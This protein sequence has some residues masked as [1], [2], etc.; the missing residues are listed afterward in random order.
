ML[1]IEDLVFRDENYVIVNKPSGLLVHPSFI[2]KY[3]TESAMKQL[4]D[5][6]GQW[7]FPIHRLDRPTSGALVFGLSSEAAAK[8]GEEFSQ[9]NVD[10]VYIALVRGYTDPQG[11]IDYP[12]KE[13]WDKMTDKDKNRNKPAQEAITE[14]STLGKVE[15]PIAVAPH[16]SS[17]YSLVAIRPKTGRQRQIRRHFKHIF[18]HL[19]GDPKHGD[20]NH[21]KMLKLNFGCARLMLHSFSIS[22]INPYSGNF[23]R[24]IAPIPDNFNSVLEGMGLA[25]LVNESVA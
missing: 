19:I 17:R 12:L 6:L 20:G 23:I 11:I 4:R 14:Y 2:D 25:G 1:S 16:P 3:E 8:L 18:H 24:A 7:V 9:R 13:I 10:K 15:L 22:F 5:L 21:N